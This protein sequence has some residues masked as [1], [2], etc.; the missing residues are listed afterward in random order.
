M[1]DQCLVMGHVR[2]L[3]NATG[4]ISFFYNLMYLLVETVSIAE[5]CFNAI[6]MYKDTAITSRTNHVY[7]CKQ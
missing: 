4:I 1:S 2:K 5:L 3:V 7:C 6:F